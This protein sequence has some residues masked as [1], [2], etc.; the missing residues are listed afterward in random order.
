MCGI[1]T[2]YHLTLGGVDFESRKNRRITIGKVLV[3]SR[4]CADI[5]KL[6]DTETETG[7]QACARLLSLWERLGEGAKL[8]SEKIAG[9]TPA[10]LS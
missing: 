4:E 9:L 8:E 3:P 10:L 2:H 5:L 1:Q 6:L 7:G